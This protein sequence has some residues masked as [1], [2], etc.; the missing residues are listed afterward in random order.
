MEDFHFEALGQ[1]FKKS[2]KGIS[3]FSCSFDS[4]F[5]QPSNSKNVSHPMEFLVIFFR[6]ENDCMCAV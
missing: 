1:R 6:D 2:I 3:L 4:A 5:L